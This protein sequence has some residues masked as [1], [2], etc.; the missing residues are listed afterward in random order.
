MTDTP[1]SFEDLQSELKALSLAASDLVQATREVNDEDLS[2][3]LTDI[4]NLATAVSNGY[5]GGPL[6][7]SL[8]GQLNG[9]E[10]VLKRTSIPAMDPD[11][12]ERTRSI[13]VIERSI[14][15]VLFRV[16][17]SKTVL[18]QLSKGKVETN[19]NDL[20]TFLVERPQQD[21]AL[22]EIGARLAD[23]ES[24]LSA[25]QQ[26]GEE[27]HQ[28][29]QQFSLL[30]ISA[31]D[32]RINLEIAKFEAIVADVIDVASLS[33][34]IEQIGLSVGLLYQSA[35]NMVRTVTNSVRERA[36]A[37]AKSGSVLVKKGKAF[38]QKMR[39]RFN[40][41]KTD[42]S[43]S[44]SGEGDKPSQ[45]KQDAADDVEGLADKGA[46]V[47]ELIKD[48]VSSVVNGV[49]NGATALSNLAERLLDSD[50]VYPDSDSPPPPFDLD[51]IKENLIKG[52]PPH[53]AHIP[54]IEELDFDD[55]ERLSDLSAFRSL[56]H[57]KRLDA[58][59]TSVVDVSALSGLTG[60]QTLYLSTTGVS[61]VSALSGLMGLQTLYLNDTGVSDVSA[62]SGLT[63]LERLDLSGTG[64][65]DVSALSDLKGLQTLFLNKTGVSDVS[66]LSGLTSLQ[67]LYL[68]RT[69]V[70][71]VSA[72]SGLTG[73]QTL[74][75]N[76][77]GVS[78]VSPLS[79]LTNLKDLRFQ[80]TPVTPKSLSA[81]QPLIEAGL[82][83][84]R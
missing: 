83:V 76:D 30:S 3:K 17:S 55:D 8:R 24:K 45:K 2:R 51:E 26:A 44:V 84:I 7:Q 63:G 62:L 52:I 82:Q 10:S 43:E 79:G 70:S 9:L 64:V 72:L 22:A 33:R 74:Y 35:T 48:P 80:G 42:G 59:R 34:A 60:L 15:A 46:A 77:T 41:V 58:D 16:Q 19:A 67:E 21:E 61:D 31:R 37:L 36:R 47:W 5:I 53:P 71:D 14:G 66:A 54:K 13:Q 73:L 69:G 75:L 11:L 38:V 65:S 78:D 12:G 50:S 49:R 40:L 6:P 39:G 18:E 25:T 29:S 32:I 56:R 4:S 57:L 28:S 68:S 23:V 20:G 27:G 81:L 1:P